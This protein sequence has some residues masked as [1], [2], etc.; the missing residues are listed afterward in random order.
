MSTITNR[1]SAPQSRAGSAAASLLLVVTAVIWGAAFLAQKLGSDHLGPFAFTGARSFLGGLSLIV[2]LAAA[3]RGSLRRALARA[4]ARPALVAGLSTG[5]ALFIA[6]A[7]QQVGI[8]YTTP[9]ISGFLTSVY[10]LFVPLLGLCLGQRPRASLWPAIAVA[11]SGLH[12]IC[13]RPGEAFG[14]GPGET[15]TLICAV[16]F[17]VQILVVAHF[18]PRTDTLAMSCVQFFT[19]AVLALPFLALP[20]ES[21]MLHLA[22]LRAAMPGILFCGVFSS[23]IA[24][25]LQNVAQGKV[26]PA[27]AALIMSLESV[28]ALLFGWL[29]RGDAQTPRQLLGCALVFVA[30]VLVQV[31]DVAFPRREP[32]A[33]APGA[34][35]EPRGGTATPDRE[36]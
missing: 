24:Y 6:S 4:T 29:L 23:G 18:A 2:V 8:G 7:F 31:V 9:G 32:G 13:I 11:L 5:T 33:G 12:L 30:V 27:I 1:P 14:I 19:G 15:L 36:P 22:N 26:P 28:F 25:T 17:A 3:E 35:Q 34:G 20:S 21:R 16:C 10:I